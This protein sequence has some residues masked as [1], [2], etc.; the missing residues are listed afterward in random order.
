MKMKNVF[1]LP[2]LCLTMLCA[3]I[4]RAGDVCS[5]CIVV[6]GDTRTDHKAHKKVVDRILARKPAVAFHTGDMVADGS[7]AGQWKTFKKISAK[8]MKNSE[9]FP[10]RGN[11][12]ELAPYYF[13]TFGLKD[14]MSWYSVDRYGI[15]FTVVD[16]ESPLWKGTY[17]YSWIKN[18]LKKA[19]SSDKTKFI[20]VLLHRPVYSTGKHGTRDAP[21]VAEALVPLFEKYGV[22]V[23][24][25]GHDHQYERSYKNGIY[26]VVTG[27]GGA[28][29]YDQVS[30]SAISQMYIKTFHYIMLSMDGEN[31][32]AEV[33]NDSDRLIDSFKIEAK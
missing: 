10:V 7:D 33:F 28:P 18:D 4:C 24:F 5:R 17:Q 32:V 16:S 15:H 13:K 23:I 9:F 2:V 14:W 22:D 30:T 20:V 27:G 3:G 12:E 1:L 25:T 6:Y 8:L 11:H 29:L 19:S 26:Y 31:F 21:V